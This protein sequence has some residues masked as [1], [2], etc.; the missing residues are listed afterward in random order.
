MDS[1]QVELPLRVVVYSSDR[2]VRDLVHTSLG[3]RPAPDLPELAIADYA[4][5]AATVRAMD[6]GDVALAI[7]DGEAQPG[8]MGIARQLKDEIFRCPPILILT[9]RPQDA[10]LATWSRADAV[11]P[12][13]VSP[14]ELASAAVQLLRAGQAAR[15][16]SA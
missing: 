9:G 2:E 1:E 4:T 13:P 5:E 16:V 8:G 3:R 12:R 15:A 14:Y 10:W 6:A 11:V 7:L